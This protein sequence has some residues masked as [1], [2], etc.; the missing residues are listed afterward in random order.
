MARHCN[1]FE[2]HGHRSDPKSPFTVARAVDHELFF[3]LGM[4]RRTEDLVLVPFVV[5]IAARFDHV[6]TIGNFD[7]LDNEGSANPAGAV[8]DSA[9]SNTG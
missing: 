9:L 3:G 8:R 2:K 4:F 6:H 1:G 7:W 5:T